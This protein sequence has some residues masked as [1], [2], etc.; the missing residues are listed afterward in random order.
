[1]FTLLAYDDP[2]APKTTIEYEKDVLM[3]KI[4][5]TYNLSDFLVDIGSL[6]GFWLGL[7]VF[8]L[9]D[10]AENLAQFAKNMIKK[11]Y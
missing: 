5:V 4:V 2:N 10:L 11:F 7:S 3:T 9:T 8:G 1:M 6:L